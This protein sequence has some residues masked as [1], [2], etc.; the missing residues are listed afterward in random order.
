MFIR[1][2]MKSNRISSIIIIIK[3]NRE[4]NESFQAYLGHAS[5]HHLNTFFLKNFSEMTCSRSST[6]LTLYY[7][8]S[9]VK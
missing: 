1:Q 4:I 9:F 5:N 7:H 3:S 6:T 8:Y 2:R